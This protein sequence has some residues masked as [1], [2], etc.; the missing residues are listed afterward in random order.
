M[1]TSIINT[2]S[3]YTLKMKRHPILLKKKDCVLQAQQGTQYNPK[4]PYP[5]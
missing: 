4:I 3:F 1:H 2:I 5:C